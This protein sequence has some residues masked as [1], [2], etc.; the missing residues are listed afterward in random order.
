M[1]SAILRKAKSWRRNPVARQIG[2]LLYVRKSVNVNA[3]LFIYTGAFG[4]GPRHFELWSSD[5]DDTCAGTRLS[6]FTATLT[7]LSSFSFAIILCFV[8]TLPRSQVIINRKALPLESEGWNVLRPELD[9]RF[10]HMPD[11]SVSGG[12]SPIMRR[13][14]SHV[15][16]D[17][18]TRDERNRGEIVPSGEQEPINSFQSLDDV[19]QWSP[20]TVTIL[21]NPWTMS[22]TGVLQL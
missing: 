11:I 6:S 5:E 19:I 20:S 10:P 1:Q 8:F 3:P 17:R 9:F 4:N 7:S 21:S 15:P 16:R 22:S 12:N 2:N 18:E 14:R 13:K